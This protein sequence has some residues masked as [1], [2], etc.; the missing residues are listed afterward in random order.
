MG[1]QDY[2]HVM[3]CS[4]LKTKNL[5]QT[6]QHRGGEGKSNRVWDQETVFS[7]FVNWLPYVVVSQ[8]I[9]VYF[10][11]FNLSESRE[12]VTEEINY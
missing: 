8:I 11:V 3:P 10:P 9:A 1:S 6:E 5:R 12:E 7:Q 2:T 4:T